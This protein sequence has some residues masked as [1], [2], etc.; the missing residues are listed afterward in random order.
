MGCHPIEPGALHLEVL[1]DPGR[2][3]GEATEHVAVAG[4]QFTFA[5][6]DVR[7]GAEPVHLTVCEAL[8][9]I[10]V[11]RTSEFQPTAPCFLSTVSRLRIN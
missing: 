7:E 9:R 4:D 6:L 5:V 10:V 11:Y 2:Q 3:L 8:G 1:R